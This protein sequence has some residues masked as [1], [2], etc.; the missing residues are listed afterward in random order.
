[1]SVDF[2]S[3]FLQTVGVTMAVSASLQINTTD[4]E[5]V[6]E[7]LTDNLLLEPITVPPKSLDLEAAGI[8]AISIP[9]TGFQLASISGV[10]SVDVSTERVTIF[11]RG[12]LQVGPPGLDVFDM[13]VLARLCTDD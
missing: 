8:M 12:D 6:I 7:P 5:R 3:P 4:E 9:G 10:F 2:S 13:E 11:S 1:M